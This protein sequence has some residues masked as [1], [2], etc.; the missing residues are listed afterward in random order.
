MHTVTVIMKDNGKPQDIV[1][2]I[3]FT[4]YCSQYIVHRILLSPLN[5]EVWKYS[6]HKNE[7]DE[8]VTNNR[9]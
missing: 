7:F 1:H 3:L 9:F 6:L 4:G 8:N 2:R 5:G